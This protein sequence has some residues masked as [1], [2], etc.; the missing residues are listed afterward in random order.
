[1]TNEEIKEIQREIRETQARLTALQNT[2]DNLPHPEPQP[3]PWK[4]RRAEKGE[5]YYYWLDNCN[6]ANTT[7]ECANRDDDHRFNHGNYFRT[8][9]LAERHAKRLRSMV[10]TCAMPKVG[11]TYWSVSIVNVYYAH[12]GTWKDGEV[13]H[14]RYHK[15]L[16]FL[17]KE[18]A[19]AW[20]VEFGDVW[21]T[22]V[23]GEGE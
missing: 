12:D 6:F 19:E 22:K 15:G 4:R 20:I 17:T 23:D 21:T 3:E 7:H 11:D 1:M 16:V 14:A 8:Q 5:K 13:H 9:E 2:L 18:S 10:P